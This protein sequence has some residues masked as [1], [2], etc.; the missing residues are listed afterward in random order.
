MTLSDKLAHGSVKLTRRIFDWVTGYKALPIPQETLDMRPIP[1]EQLRKD[2]MLLS[3]K[4]WMSRIIVL[5]SI[6]GVPGMVA[7][8]LRHLRS[9]RRLVSVFQT[10]HQRWQG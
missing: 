7:G 3:D 4:M 8:T 6:A 2:G 5:E 10:P 1:I 9:L